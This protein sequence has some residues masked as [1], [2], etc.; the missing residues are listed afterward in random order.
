MAELERTNERTTQYWHGK[1]D[2]IK[3]KEAASLMKEETRDE[4]GQAAEEQEA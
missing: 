2:W 4:R 3:K 1:L